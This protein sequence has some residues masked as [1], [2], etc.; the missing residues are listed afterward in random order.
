MV[1]TSAA[2]TKRD[3]PKVSR[4][5][6]PLDLVHLA[7]Q[8]LGDEGLEQEVLRLFDTTISTYLVRL[9]KAEDVQGVGLNLHSIRSAASGVGAWSVV[10]QAKAAEEELQAQGQVSPERLDDIAVQ[11]EEVRSFIGSM[12]RNDS[13]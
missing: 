2:A 5:Q 11:I 4:P 7:R 3:E 6:R 13:L 1:H 8:C 10:D 12:L 9:T